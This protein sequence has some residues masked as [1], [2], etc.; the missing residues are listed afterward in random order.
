MMWIGI[1]IGLLIAWLAAEAYRY[2]G[3]D[4]DCDKCGLPD[5]L[6]RVHEKSKKL[7]NEVDHYCSLCDDYKAK[8]EQAHRREQNLMTGIANRDA[9]IDKLEERPCLCDD[10]QGVKVGGS[11]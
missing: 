9:I 1:A 3:F 7:A 6:H 10:G 2:L 11:C 5:L 8:L 4:A